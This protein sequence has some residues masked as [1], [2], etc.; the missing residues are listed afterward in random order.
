MAINWLAL[1][2]WLTLLGS[3]KCPDFGSSF[4]NRLRYP[5]IGL[6]LSGI[7]YEATRF[8]FGEISSR[9][10]STHAQLLIML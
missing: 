10:V 3:I 4:G 6:S 5:K 7:L 1:H 2:N 8:V 9:L